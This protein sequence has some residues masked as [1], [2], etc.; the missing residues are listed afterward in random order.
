MH[1]S[2][3]SVYQYPVNQVHTW[4]PCTQEV[5]VGKSEISS[6]TLQAG[7]LCA[8]RDAPHRTKGYLG[9]PPLLL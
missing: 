3:V 1:T 7:E 9:V 8:T 5:E 4:N 6:D 2:L